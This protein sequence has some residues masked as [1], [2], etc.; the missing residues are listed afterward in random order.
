MRILREKLR[1][2]QNLGWLDRVIRV[3]VGS[4]MLIYPAY[5]L[6]TTDS[7]QAQWPFYSMLVSI[8]P[9]L[10]GIVGYDPLYKLFGVRTC[11]TTGKN[12]CGTFPY[13]VDAA[14]G[15]KPIPN[16]NIEHSLDQSRH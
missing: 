12:S 2:P 10:T 11:N 3:L 15:N 7:T 9:W 1:V 8:Y 13:E 6:A 4:A 14:L 5:L 16:S